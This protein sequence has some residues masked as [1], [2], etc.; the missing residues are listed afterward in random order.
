MNKEEAVIG[1]V[2]GLAFIP[3]I[4]LWAIPLALGTSFLWAYGGADKTSKGFRRF[5]VPL[6]T[7]FA[8]LLSLNSWTTLLTVPGA[9]AILSI[10]YGI[11]SK[12][13]I[14]EGSVLGRFWFKIVGGN[15]YLASILTRAT[16][17]SALL[18]NYLVIL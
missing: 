12:Q 17:Y 7:A 9:I 14:D 13:P 2:F 10:G 1:G 15:E 16:I 6:I 5:G 11:P 4:G 18:T 8:L 3:V